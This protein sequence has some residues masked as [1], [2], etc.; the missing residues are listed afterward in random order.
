MLIECFF[1]V[2]CG[3]VIVLFVVLCGGFV[4]CVCVRRLCMCVFC[5]VWWCSVLCVLMWCDDVVL[6]CW[7]L[8][9]GGFF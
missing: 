9:V 3:G 1:W 7:G 4:L 8:V 6:K 5:V 2:L